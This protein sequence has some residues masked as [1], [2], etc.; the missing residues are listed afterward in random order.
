MSWISNQQSCEFHEKLCVRGT[1]PL[2]NQQTCPKVSSMQNLKP[3]KM[4]IG[5]DLSDMINSGNMRGWGMLMSCVWLKLCSKSFEFTL[6]LQET[7]SPFILI[8]IAINKMLGWSQTRHELAPADTQYSSVPWLV[9]VHFLA[10]FSLLVFPF[11]NKLTLLSRLALLNL[12]D[13]AKTKLT[14]TARRRRRNNKQAAE[15]YEEQR[16]SIH[17][18]YVNV[19]LSSSCRQWFINFSDK[20]CPWIQIQRESEWV[21]V[22]QRLAI[23][24]QNE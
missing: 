13:G 21:H 5:Q 6:F 11:F 16:P 24:T 14:K 8:V 17:V 22:K 10:R 19:Y 2:S 15:Q 4:Y 3:C 9:Q 7:S 18:Y 1:L 20:F 23:A 12:A